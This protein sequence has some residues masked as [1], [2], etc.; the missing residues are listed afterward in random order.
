MPV[1]RIKFRI[2][3]HKICEEGFVLLIILLKT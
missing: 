1:L 2:E 3:N